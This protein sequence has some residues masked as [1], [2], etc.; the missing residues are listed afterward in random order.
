VHILLL[1][2]LFNKADVSRPAQSTH[3]ASGDIWDERKM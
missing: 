3:I 2:V 1:C